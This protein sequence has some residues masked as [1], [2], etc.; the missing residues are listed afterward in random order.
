MPQLSLDDF[1]EAFSAKL[2]ER[3]QRVLRL[4]DTEV[5]NG[6]QRIYRLLE[7]EAA[8]VERKTSADVTW[9]SS[10]SN[11]RNVFQPSP[12]G[13]FDELE[14]LLRAKQVYLTDHPN[15]YYQAIVIKLP[16]AAAKR[17]IQG[18]DAPSFELVDKA[19]KT[20]LEPSR[21]A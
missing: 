9:A 18:L 14:A 17:I 5:R 15:P 2:V 20:Y 1:I 21:A 16:L 6:L 4:N 19:V 12:I 13:S 8:D 3:G 7:D 10:V 11:I